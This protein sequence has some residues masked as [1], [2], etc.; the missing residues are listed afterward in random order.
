MWKDKRVSVILPTY[1]EKD[2]IRR[3]VREFFESGVVD[4]VIVVNNNAAPGTDDEVRPTP[5]RLV[6]ESKQGYGH[7]IQRGLAEATGDFLVISEPDGTFFGR[8]VHKLL[9]YADDFEVVFGTRTTRELIWDGANMEWLIR[10]G[11]YLVAK[12]MEWLFNTGF[13][14][15]VGCTMRLLRREVYLRIRDGFTIGGSHF[16]PELMMLVILRG[17]RFIEIPVNYGKR[18]GESSVTGDK[19]RA[20]QLGVRMTL[21][22][23]EYRWKSWIGRIPSSPRQPLARR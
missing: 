20:F 1:N 2:S 17:A 6:H 21:L 5:A 15:D 19:W 12:F 7:A 13:L 22:I 14:S 18:V 4:E 10:T 8:D 3:V 11:N 16:G 9:A 23:V